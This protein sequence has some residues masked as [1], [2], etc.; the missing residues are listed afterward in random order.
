M[1][2]GKTSERDREKRKRKKS[3]FETEIFNIVEKSL[4]TVL[5]KALDDILKDFK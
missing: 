5:D 4:K 3:S 1:K 2:I